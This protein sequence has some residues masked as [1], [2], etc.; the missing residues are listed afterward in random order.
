M[1]L[2]ITNFRKSYE[3]QQILGIPNLKLNH[4]IYWIKGG[5]GSGKSTLFKTICGISPFDG[6]ISLD[7]FSCKRDPKLYRQLVSYSEAEPLY[8]DFLT[9]KD[10]ILFY[11]KTRKA[12]QIQV[13]ALINQ[14]DTNSFLNQP[15]KTFSSGMLKKV[16][17]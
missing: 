3:S 8:P 1:T 11:A 15:I 2:S 17:L 10:L 13:D 9:Q 14:L 6:K 4:G 12:N 5:N 7:G 16:G